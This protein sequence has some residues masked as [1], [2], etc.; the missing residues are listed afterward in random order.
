[1]SDIEKDLE[2]Q[3]AEI[4]AAVEEGKITPEDGEAV[5]K[6]IESA[7]EALGVAKKEL[8]VSKLVTAI[9]VA[10]AVI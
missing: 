1:M 2:N 6:E 7:M 8:L 5:L 10:K 3:I 4:S 9:N